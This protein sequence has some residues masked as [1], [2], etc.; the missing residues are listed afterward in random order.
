MISDHWPSCD[1]FLSGYLSANEDD[2]ENFPADQF[3]A[4]LERYEA[5]FGAA[6]RF[7]GLSKES[8][9]SKPELD[10]SARNCPFSGRRFRAGSYIVV[11]VI[12]METV[13][14]LE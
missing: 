1:Y 4:G 8:L 11:D 12:A 10:S 9:K 3:P 14:P 7:L 2:P 13:V 5:I 6:L